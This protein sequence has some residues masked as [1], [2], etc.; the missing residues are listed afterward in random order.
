[1]KEGI[2]E[3]EMYLQFQFQDPPIVQWSPHPGTKPMRQRVEYM[4]KGL[5]QCTCFLERGG[6][7]RMRRERG[8]YAP[9]SFL[10]I[11]QRKNDRK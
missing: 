6:E 3:K 11:F 1:M 9:T 8:M 2:G 5:R 4:R 7:H 10:L